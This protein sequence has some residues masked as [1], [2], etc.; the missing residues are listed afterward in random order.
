MA[1]TQ[2]CQ[3]SERPYA[4]QKEVRPAAYG[5]EGRQAPDLFPD[6]TLWHGHVK[7]AIL[8]AE[9]GIALVTQFVKVWVVGPHV[10][11]KLKLAHQACTT[12]KR[13]DPS[14]DPVIRRTL[15]QGRT[16]SPPAPDHLS[17]VHVHCGI[18]RVHAPNVR[19][20]RAGI[21]VRVHGSV[22]EIII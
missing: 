22:T 15:W 17:P 19:T 11:R 21:T 7:C 10:H 5:R 9:N 3:V 14:L 16:V 1:I 8:S 12:D 6:G 4:W 18:A 20:E 13:G 2:G